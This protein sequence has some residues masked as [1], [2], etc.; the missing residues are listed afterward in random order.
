MRY[1]ENYEEAR[2][3]F[4]TAARE[5]G[6]RLVA[7]VHPDQVSPSGKPLEIDVAVL[8]PDRSRKAILSISG[9]H[10]LEACSGSAAQTRFLEQKP[11]P[12]LGTSIVMIHCLNPFGLAWSSRAN[13]DFVDLSRSFVPRRSVPSPNPYYADIHALL[14]PSVWSDDAQ[15][16]FSAALAQLMANHGPQAALTGVTG[17][18]YE[19]RDGLSYGGDGATWSRQVLESVCDRWL[20]TTDKI[21]YLDFHSGFGEFAEA[22]FVCFHPRGSSERRR[23]ETWWGRLNANEDAFGIAAEPE[24]NGLIWDGLRNWIL[25]NASICG[26]VIEFGTYDLPKVAEA[27]MID[28]WLRFGQS[29][30]PNRSELRARMIETFNPSSN[31]WRSRVTEKGSALH[32]AALAGLGEW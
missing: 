3:Y 21:A 27:L 31:T 13:E 7:Y 16:R 8:G 12:P 9:T 24:W 32:G 25:P 15:A 4:R 19:F 22:F 2:L 6:A 17:G 5:A 20:G 1:P 11:S 30:E 14:T 10:G 23:V 18:Q 28:R 29:A 26:A